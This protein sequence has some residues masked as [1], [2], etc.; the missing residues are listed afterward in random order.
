MENYKLLSSHKQKWDICTSFYFVAPFSAPCGKVLVSSQIPSNTHILALLCC[1]R[2][3]LQFGAE[4][5]HL[6]TQKNQ[7]SPTHAKGD[8]SH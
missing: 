8:L 1:L 7:P 3:L 4:I 2:V 6:S 5:S